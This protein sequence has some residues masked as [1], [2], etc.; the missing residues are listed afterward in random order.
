LKDFTD[1]FIS[2]NNIALSSSSPLFYTE[3]ELITFCCF[4]N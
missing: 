1:W 2:T 3:Y 4:I